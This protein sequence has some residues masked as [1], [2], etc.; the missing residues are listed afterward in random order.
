MNQS[1]RI[2]DTDYSA[3]V[4]QYVSDFAMDMK[5]RKVV[6]RSS[7]PNNPALRIIVRLKGQPQ[8]TTWALLHMPPHFARNSLLAFKVMRIEFA[9]RGPLLNPDTTAQRREDSAP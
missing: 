7:E 5:T 4:V 3:R 1:F 8:D 9:G 6:S 2:G